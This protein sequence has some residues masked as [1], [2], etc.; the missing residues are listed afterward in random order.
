[1]R[2][3]GCRLHPGRVFDRLSDPGKGVGAIVLT[4][5]RG[6]EKADQQPVREILEGGACVGKHVEFSFMPLLRK[7]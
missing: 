5:F 3:E 1:M 2:R 6:E 4:A 7:R